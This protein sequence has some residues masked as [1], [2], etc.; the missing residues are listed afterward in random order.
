M[1]RGYGVGD[2]FSQDPVGS[3]ESRGKNRER[4]KHKLDGPTLTPTEQHIRD[5]LMRQFMRNPEG[6][7]NGEAYKNAS[8]WC[9][10]GRGLK[11]ESGFCSRCEANGEA[12]MAENYRRLYGAEWRGVEVESHEVAD[13]KAYFAAETEQ[14]LRETDES[15]A[16]VGRLLGVD[17]ETPRP[18][19]G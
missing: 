3:D 6:E 17:A 1:K 19:H 8:C 12:W 7:P 11:A 18:E 14:V 9:E 13:L 2:K 10:C 5:G 16:F 15:A 4:R